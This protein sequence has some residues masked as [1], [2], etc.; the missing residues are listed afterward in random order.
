MGIKVANTAKIFLKTPPAQF[1]LSATTWGTWYSG[2]A[3]NPRQLPLKYTRAKFY[4]RKL[5]TIF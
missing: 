5:D 1:R 3:N 2:L 4:G